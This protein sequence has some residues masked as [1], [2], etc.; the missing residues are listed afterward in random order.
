MLV[1]Y[2]FSIRCEV[3]FEV[4]FDFKEQCQVTATMTGVLLIHRFT[5]SRGFKD[6][7]ASGVAWARVFPAEVGASR[8]IHQSHLIH[9]PA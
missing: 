7:S 6:F 8:H 1:G 4:V 5:S 3:V 9:R 2:M